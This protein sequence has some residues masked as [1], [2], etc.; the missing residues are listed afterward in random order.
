VTRRKDP[1]GHGNLPAFQQGTTQLETD[2]YGVT[3][4]AS[5]AANKI[6]TARFSL[7]GWYSFAD[8]QPKIALAD[9]KTL[10]FAP[11]Y[12]TYTPDFPVFTIS[13]AFTASI[14]QIFIPRDYNTLHFNDDFSWIRGPHNIQLGVDGIYTVQSDQNMSRTNGSYT[15]NGNFSGLGLT[16]FMLGRPSLFRQGSPAPDD[17]R[18]LHLAWYIQ[19]DW[20]V[21][22]R[23]TLNAG[24]RHELPRAP[25]ARNGAAMAWR[26]GRQSTVY[27]NAPP[28]LLFFGDP[29]IPRSGRTISNTLF[30]PRIGLA[31]ALTADQKTLIRAGYGIYINPSWSN[32][33]GQFA[34]Y[35]PFTRI[36]DINAAPSTADPWIGFPG[37]NPHP[38][39]PKPPD[40]V[41]DREITALSYGPNFKELTMQQWN[42][43]VQREFSGN[44]LVTA[45]YVG[46]R[47]S[48]IPYLRDQN[49]ATFIPGQSTVANLNQRRPL[50]PYFSRFSLIESVINS[51][52]NSFQASVDRRFRGGFTVLGSY[53]FSKALSDLNTVL[54]NTG[55]ET[56]PDNRRLDWGPADVDRT[57]AFITSWIWQVPS[58]SFRKNIANAILSG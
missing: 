34:I 15:F 24:L 19:D 14:E 40:A 28:G 54:T 8:Y 13:G 47:G 48:H 30:A 18:A 42:I 58:G 11:N 21:S 27:R 49:P 57:H 51:N 23:L 39:T 22:R 9:L 2:L 32:I 41:F 7:N 45:G 55:G 56:D 25:H 29:D 36:I 4:T 38:Y 52:Y 50:Y 3:H 46:S 10:G 12:Y 1:T 20:K 6:N 35:Q 33:E 16:D 53:T 26:P 17:V 31:Y 43:T 37:G 5:L 44:W